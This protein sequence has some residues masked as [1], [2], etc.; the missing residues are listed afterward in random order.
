M[1]KL[2]NKSIEWLAYG[3]LLAAPLAHAQL[4]SNTATVTLNATLAETLTV[5]ATPATVSFALVAGGTASGSAPV[6]ITTSWVLASG[7]ANVVL[8]GYFSSATAALSGGT[9]TVNIPTSEILGQMTTGTPTTYTAFTQSGVV[10]TAG[11]GL[12]LFTQAL[13]SSNRSSTRTDNLNLEI[14]LASQ[15]QL[16]AATYTGTLILQ[17]QAL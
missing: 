9:P 17:A 16:P 15:T 2:R 6:T 13:S 4:N 8:D 5:A 12:T 7:R 1:M 14:N 10:G 11:A 3:V